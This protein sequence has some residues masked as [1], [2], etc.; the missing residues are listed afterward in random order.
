M[1]DT[2]SMATWMSIRHEGANSPTGFDW[3][4]DSQVP[5]DLDDNAFLQRGTKGFDSK[6]TRKQ[7]V[8]PT[9]SMFHGR[10]ASAEYQPRDQ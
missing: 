4:L 6:A 5:L 10:L 1:V 3:R 2:L 8:Y 7:Q 9:S